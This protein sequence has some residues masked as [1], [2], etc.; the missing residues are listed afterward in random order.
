VAE[1][2]IDVHGHAIVPAAMA[3]AGPEP[4]AQAA[5]A[6]EVAILGPETQA[7]Q[8]A[9]IERI[10]P[11]LVDVE[12]RL[13][14]L[15]R[16][17]IDQ[18]VVSPSPAHYCPWAAP[19]LAERIA[20]VTNEGIVAHCAE[21]D[22]LHGLGYAPLQ[23]AETALLDAMDLGL[24]GVEISTFEPGID[25]SS[26]ELAGF[27]ARAEELGALVFIHP[28]GCTLDERLSGSYM[29]NLVGQPVE[30]TVALSHVIMS[31]L[32]DRHPRLRILAA[33]GGGYLPFHPARMDHGWRV[34]PE[35]TRPEE[36]PSS[37]LRRIWFD[38][39]VYEPGLLDVLVE[40]VGADRVLMGTDFPFDMGV[41]D[42]VALVEASGL[43][44]A[45]RAAVRGGNAAGLLGLEVGT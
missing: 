39:V 9:M 1:P 10:G 2:V 31:G 36:L 23:I 43:D 42:P 24:H 17:G 29:T 16:A 12:A 5:R 26:P 20:R 11:L 6:A 22:R 41:E 34:R 7:V 35:L 21:S 3:L 38:S 25:L 37:Y 28:W 32:L 13:A 30:H 44:D 45:A 15:D 8:E 27:W 19:S 4:A 14:A 33:H 18:Q 40:R